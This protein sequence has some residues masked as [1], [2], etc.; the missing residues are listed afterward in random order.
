MSEELSEYEGL[1]LRRNVTPGLLD[2]DQFQSSLRP[3]TMS[4]YIGQERIR[5]NLIIAVG[6]AKKRGDVLDHVLLHGPPGLG[7]TTLA[8]VIANELGVSFKATSGPVLE[9]PGDL[10]AML[11]SLNEGDVLFIDEIHRLSRVVEEILYPAMEDFQIDI[12]IGQGPASRSIKLNLKSFTL[13]GATTR[14]GLLT[15]PLRDRFGITERMEFYS[16]PELVQVLLRSAQI[17]DIA[18][19]HDGA[20]EIAR[21]SRGTPRIANRLL[22]RARDYATERADSV[23][24]ATVADE[25]LK[26]LDIDARGFDRMDR[27]FLKTII[28]KFSGGPVGIET[29]AAA[30]HEDK[31]TLEDVCE[32]YLLS[33]GFIMRT[34]RGREATESAY[35]HLGLKFSTS[36]DRRQTN[37]F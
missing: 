7:K 25:A 6:A 26:L 2:E 4:E 23:I 36:S 29:I 28:E 15:A 10:A 24:T 32:P 16:E 8:A 37:L 12:I 17:L 13:I 27:L 14:T 19:D 22:K 1:S 34:P 11:S 33:Q 5:E 9:R 20:M 3:K 35:H 30:L 18:I 31:D 21:R